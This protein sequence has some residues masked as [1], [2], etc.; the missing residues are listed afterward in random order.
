MLGHAITAAELYMK[1]YT[2]ATN[3]SQRAF[4]RRKCAE[5]I[6]LAE[7]HKSREA[8][9]DTLHAR[10]ITPQEKVILHESSRLNGN[11]FPP[12]ESDPPVDVF[13]PLPGDMHFRSATHVF[14]LE[15]YIP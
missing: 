12:W 11:Y 10:Q 5:M 15:L 6:A 7:G 3:P 2:I 4:L 13:L 1:S 14:L 9:H 8:K